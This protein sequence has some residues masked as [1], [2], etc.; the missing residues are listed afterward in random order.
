MK[1]KDRLMVMSILPQ[2]GNFVTIQLVAELKRKVSLSPKEIEQ[3]GIKT[4]PATGNL[5]WDDTK[6]K[7]KDFSFHESERA[8]IQKALV[9]LEEQNKLTPDHIDIYKQFVLKDKQDN[10]DKKD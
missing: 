5:A 9:E 3:V 6:D 8:L 1:I 4:D 7:D 2:Q 10:D